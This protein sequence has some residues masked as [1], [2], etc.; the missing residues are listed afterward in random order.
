M[1]VYINKNYRNHYIGELITN[2]P[3]ST[4]GQKVPITVLVSGETI[5]IYIPAL[6]MNIT[7]RIVNGELQGTW[8]FSNGEDHGG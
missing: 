1:N 2:G 5:L 8:G 4:Q 3:Y 7:G 6:E